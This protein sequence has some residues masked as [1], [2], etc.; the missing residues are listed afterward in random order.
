MPGHNVVHVTNVN[1]HT[2]VTGEIV[3]KPP[4][5]G[6]LEL[7]TPVQ[8]NL[9][10]FGVGTWERTTRNVTV[11]NHHSTIFQLFLCEHALP[12][13][14]FFRLYVEKHESHRVVCTI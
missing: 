13:R 3:P 7:Y 2:N 14:P 11:H 12:L 10:D 1:L 5:G 8:F 6:F 4:N 9:G